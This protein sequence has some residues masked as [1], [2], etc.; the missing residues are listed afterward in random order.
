MSTTK[1][2]GKHQA[3]RLVELKEQMHY[4]VEVSDSI[5]FLK[6]RLEEIYEKADAID[7]VT[8]RLDG[9]PIQELLTRVD[10]LETKVVRTGNYEHGDSSTSYV[11]HI[12]ERVVELDSSQKSIMEMINSMSKDFRATLDVVRNEI[13][14]AL[15]NFIFDLEQYFKATST[16]TE[17][18]KVTLA[19]MHLSECGGGLDMSTF[20]KGIA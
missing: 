20:T 11:S 14:D 18:A 19:T 1:Q 3:D 13:A 10:T 15:E 7:A 5:H 6:S 9:L 17:E 12:E 4:L 16:V 8:S 2:L